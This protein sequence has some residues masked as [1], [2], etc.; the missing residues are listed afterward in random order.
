MTINI[1]FTGTQGALTNPQKRQ[2]SLVLSSC[3]VQGVIHL[4]HGDCIGADAFANDL[5]RGEFR[6]MTI[7]HPPS[8][9][10]KRAFCVCDVYLPEKPYLERNHD[11]VNSTQVLLAC[12]MGMTETLRS[13]TWATVRYAREPQKPLCIIFPDGS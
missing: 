3:K 2:L 10:K 11:I 9:P 12:P 5:W 7:A 4:H 1:G 8:D 13:G 6:G